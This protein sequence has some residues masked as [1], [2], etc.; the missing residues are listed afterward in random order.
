M[1]DLWS[2]EGILEG[3]GRKIFFAAGYILWGVSK[4]VWNLMLNYLEE[5]HNLKY[6]NG[7]RPSKLQVS[8]KLEMAFQYWRDYR[9]Y[10]K[11]AQ[12]FEVA[13]NTC[14][15]AIKWVE[16]TLIA[17]KLFAL[18]KK[19]E[20]LEDKNIKTLIVDATETPIERP[21]KTKQ[22]WYSG[23]KKFHTIKTQ[24]VIEANTGKILSVET[25]EGKMHDFK[26]WKKSKKNISQNVEI[27]ADS[28]YQGM[29][30]IYQNAKI[31]IKKKEEKS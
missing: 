13:E 16:D 4:K 1:F 11:I 14:Y 30:E 10:F 18:P 31:P 19:N 2:L 8:Q 12:D 20:V 15:L 22:K 9:T 7:G 21:V 23:K 25:S 24:L 17:S 27:L 29:Q 26:L 28:G 3:K 5:Q 6:K